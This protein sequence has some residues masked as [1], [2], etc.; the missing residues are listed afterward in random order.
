MAKK[1]PKS[2]RR[3]IIGW[4]KENVDKFPTAGKS[5]PVV[6]K[7]LPQKQNDDKK[8]QAALHSRVNSV[9]AKTSSWRP[10]AGI[11]LNQK[12]DLVVIG[13][14]AAGVAGAIRAASRGCFVLL[15]D[16]YQV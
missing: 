8:I 13:A 3:T 9:V 12:Y 15:V 6:G 14:G 5:K 1:T 2:G 7:L 16:G 4:Y 10:P 11:E